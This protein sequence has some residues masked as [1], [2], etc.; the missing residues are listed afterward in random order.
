[1][2]LSRLERFKVKE[3]K[4]DDEKMSG[5]ICTKIYNLLAR[6]MKCNTN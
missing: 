3:R 5:K 4:N 6:L 2:T 1:M